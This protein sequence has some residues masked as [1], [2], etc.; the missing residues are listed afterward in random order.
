MDSNAN[1]EN[2]TRDIGPF[3]LMKIYIH[4]TYSLFEQKQMSDEM[5]G[6]KD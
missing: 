4:Q 5:S 2:V 6:R 1:F 3:L